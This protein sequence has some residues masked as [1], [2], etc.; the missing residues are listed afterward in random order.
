MSNNKK[1]VEE[2]LYLTDGRKNIICL[3]YSIENLHQMAKELGMNE[4]YF[5]KDHYVVPDHMVDEIE[6]KCGKVS[7]QTLFLTARNGLM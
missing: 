6:D 7:T 2:L 4:K 5:N 3:P 1:S